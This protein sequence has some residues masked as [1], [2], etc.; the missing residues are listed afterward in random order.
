M[1]ETVLH[2]WFSELKPA[3]W[4]KKDAYIDRVIARRFGSLLEEVAACEHYSWRK[5]PRGR[6]AEVL[7][8]DQFSRNIHRGTARAFENDALGLALA[9]EAIAAGADQSLRPDQLSFLYMPFMHS[10][11]L[12]IHDLAVELFSAPGLEDNLEF[13]LK[14]RA[15]IERFRRYPHRN[16]LL[17]RPSTPEE[18]E[19][20]KQP[21][22]GF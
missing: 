13:E 6:L 17:G 1:I 11:S 15:I 14:H 20:L 8:L 16:A 3:Q 5:K 4:F 18:V 19:F 2:F 22:S 12:R 9:Q 7:V 10:E 21:G